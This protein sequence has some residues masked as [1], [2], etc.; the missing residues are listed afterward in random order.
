MLLKIFK[1]FIFSIFLSCLVLASFFFGYNIGLE[2]GLENSLFIEIPKPTSTPNNS[3]QTVQP[4][5]VETNTKN[6]AWG[7]PELWEVVNQRRKENGVNSL[8]Q[9]NELCTIAA[10]RLNQIRT[11]EKLDNHEGFSKLREEREDLQWIF[12]QYNLAEFLIAGYSTPE[13][14][15]DAWE[16][17]LGHKS[18]VDGGEWV[19]GCIYAQDT[20]GV[21]ITAY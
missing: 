16:H 1:V 17:T 7:G 5:I 8:G 21:A 4:Q 6:V 20:F 11:L 13:A 12:N 18:L 9:K 2:Q 10:I 15:V 3:K 14:T 19:W